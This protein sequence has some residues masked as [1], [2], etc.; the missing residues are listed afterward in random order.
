MECTGFIFANVPYLN[1]GLEKGVSKVGF[2]PLGGWF[3]QKIFAISVSNALRVNS[4]VLG[5]LIPAGKPLA[6]P[7]S[8]TD[9]TYDY[10]LRGWR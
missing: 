4:A 2:A 1:T 7:L 9:M 8:S 6:I 10:I 3:A 5:K